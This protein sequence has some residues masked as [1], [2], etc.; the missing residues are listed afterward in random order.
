[1][2]NPT[3][4]DR[5]LTIYR[6]S[7]V[8]LPGSRP[9]RAGSRADGSLPTPESAPR[10]VGVVWVL[11]LINTLSFAGSV[12]M[13][14]PFPRP[15][16]QLV[17]MGS[18]AVALVLAIV[19][20]PRL[21]IRPNPFL[22]LLSLLLVV[23]LA[24]SLLLDSGVG[25][26]FRCFRLTLF[27]ATIW[28]LTRWWRG[29]LT[30]V[31]HTVRFLVV[32]L[33]SV[34]VG[35]AI[36]PSAAMWG[37]HGRLVGTLWPMSAPLV[38][39]FGAVAA[40]LV[41]IL[42]LSR[43]IDGRTTAFISAIA[44]GCVV[45]SH[46]RTALL[47][48]IIGLAGACLPLLLTSKRIRQVLAWTAA[49]TIISVG[50]FW[51]VIEQWFRR[52]QDSDQLSNLTGRQ[53]VWNALLAEDRSAFQQLLGSGLSDKSYNGAAID[54]GWLTIYV[55]QGYV[56]IGIAAAMMLCLIGAAAMRKPSPARTCAIFLILFCAVSSYTEVGL[57]DASAYL[58][59][60]AVAASLLQPRDSEADGDPSGEGRYG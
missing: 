4:D 52:G 59:Y 11:L 47:G 18:L 5:R 41:I 53:T 30:F 17:T 60:L 49:V 33:L 15:L 34:L 50:A 51:S 12:D 8:V 29:D 57:G 25:G 24:S 27:V 40:G 42:R 22:L 56:G 58:L 31:R 7:H 6:G 44:L 14:V 26:L 46:T 1:M 36:S 38:G 55:E 28:L 54:N 48:L 13:V 21:R 9:E 32:M 19:L 3:A 16:L 2:T 10:L 39:Q 20:N 43:C 37:E 45:L 35:L 23:S